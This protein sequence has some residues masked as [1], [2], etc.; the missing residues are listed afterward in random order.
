[1]V[2]RGGEAERRRGGEAERRRGGEAERRRGGEAERRRGGKRGGRGGRDERGLQEMYPLSQQC[3]R[4]IGARVLLVNTSLQKGV[5]I[6]SRL[7]AFA[8]CSLNA[9]IDQKSILCLTDPPILSLPLPLSLLYPLCL[10][11]PSPPFVFCCNDAAN[12]SDVILG[13][14]TSR[15]ARSKRWRNFDVVDIWISK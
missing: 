9:R 8:N 15:I 10:A 11:P 2:G 14:A 12:V 7:S 3:V 4:T 1:M 6:C 5:E 13:V